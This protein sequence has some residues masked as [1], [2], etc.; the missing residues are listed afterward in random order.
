M[1]RVVQQITTT[2]LQKL[3]VTHLVAMARKVLSSYDTQC[4]QL[5]LQHLLLD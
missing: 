1:G 2:A 5:Q 3:R 4:Q